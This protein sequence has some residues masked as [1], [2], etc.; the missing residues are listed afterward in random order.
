M[1]YPEAWPLRRLV[2]RTP[3]LELRPDDDAGLAELIEEAYAGVH[4]P[5]QMPFSEPWTDAD[6][7]YLG[8]G[9]FQYHW[10]QRALVSPQDWTVQ[11]LVRRDGRVIG[12]QLLAAAGFAVRREVSTGSWL[13]RRHQ[14]QGYGTEMRAAVLAF[15]FDQLGARTARSAAFVDNAASLAVSAKLGYRPDGTETWSRR[16]EAVEQI[17]L[18]LRRAD[19][20]AHRPP[21]SLRV[22]GS[23]EC[24]PLL[25]ADP[26]AEKT[27]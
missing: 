5:E 17:R 6:P 8:R 10:R 20:R 12:S 9:V 24:L 1:N 16:G 14:R 7:R 19:F 15:S 2:L 18:L 26:V 21:W 27:G 22:S 4:P 3:R 23:A 11:F 13:G 25:G